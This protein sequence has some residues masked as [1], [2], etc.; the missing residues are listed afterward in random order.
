MTRLANGAPR[1]RLETRSMRSLRLSAPLPRWLLYAVA[2]TGLVATLWFTLTPP[3]KSA[4]R[5]L[6]THDRASPGLWSSLRVRAVWSPKRVVR[7][8]ALGRLGYRPA[9]PQRLMTVRPPEGGSGP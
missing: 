4:F 6:D 3:I 9:N 5:V 7:E 1:V 8:R 2:M